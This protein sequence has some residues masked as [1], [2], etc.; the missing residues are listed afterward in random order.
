[1]LRLLVYYDDVKLLSVEGARFGTCWLYF[2]CHQHGGHE[3]GVVGKLLNIYAL[4]DDDPAL[5][6]YAFKLSVYDVDNDLGTGLIDHSKTCTRLVH[7]GRRRYVFVG[8]DRCMD[9][10]TSTEFEAFHVQYF[11]RLYVVEVRHRQYYVVNDTPFLLSA[12][13]NRINID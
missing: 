4:A 13:P 11:A 9:N 5:C 12:L 10:S 6:H 7:T 2:A 3:L 1:M 8:R